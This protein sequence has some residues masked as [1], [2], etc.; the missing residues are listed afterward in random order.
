MHV[1]AVSMQQNIAKNNDWL[2]VD[3][4]LL[5]VTHAAK[6]TIQQIN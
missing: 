6:N 1:I 3:L 5:V 2:F 4:F